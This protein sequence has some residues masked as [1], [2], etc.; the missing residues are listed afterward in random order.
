MS[1]QDNIQVIAGS[2]NVVDHLT[3]LL[4]RAKAGE[5][6]AIATATCET[7]GGGFIQYSWR[8]DMA[9]PWARLVAAAGWLHH[10]L[11]GNGL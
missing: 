3:K 10:H 5:I 2:G 11:T 7:D 8:D 9:W 1:L 4:E 6:E